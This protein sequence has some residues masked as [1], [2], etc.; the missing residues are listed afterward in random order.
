M[1]DIEVP[2]TTSPTLA[3]ALERVQ[4]NP[5]ITFPE[6]RDAGK[7]AGLIIYPVV[8]GKAR[9]MLGLGP[10]VPSR[11]R[12]QRE[13]PPQEEPAEE[14]SEPQPAAP[15][16]KPAVLQPAHDST[17]AAID[18]PVTRRGRKPRA[19]A[20]GDTM[21][22]LSASIRS[23]MEHHERMRIALDRI[24]RVVDEALA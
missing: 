23:L 15:L 4:M 18:V 6:V 10:M 3:F 16:A 14:S 17:D 13:E 8:Y 24:R 9:G 7:L 19:V 11:R 20:L 12:V 22:D 1:T 5:D 2:R 21:G